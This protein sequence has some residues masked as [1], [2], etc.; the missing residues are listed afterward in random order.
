M[1][2]PILL[3]ALA[4]STPVLAGPVD[5]VLNGYLTEA[6]QAEPSLSGFSADRGAAFF[7]ARQAGG[8]PD[9]PSCTACH[10]ETPQS[11]GR[12]KA[13]KDIGP[14][15]VS[16]EPSRYT[17]REK[18]EKWFGRNCQSVLGRACTAREKGDFIA[19]MLTQ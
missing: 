13:G 16:K 3:V 11:I 10:G 17:D 5:G 19:F 12:T 7:K 4:L 8:Q 1:R 6:R 18:T 2:M 14:L 15:A 9:T